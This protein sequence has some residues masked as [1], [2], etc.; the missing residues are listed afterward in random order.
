[1]KLLRPTLAALLALVAA[2]AWPQ[3]REAA[4][5]QALET[6]LAKHHVVGA[7]AAILE[8]DGTHYEIGAGFQDRETKVAADAKTIYRLGSV[9]KP[10]TAVA[11][12]QLVEAGRLSLFS[13][14]S[15]RVPEWPDKGAPISLRHLLTHTSGIRHYVAGKS[16]VFYEPFTVARSL[17]VFKDDDRLF[18]PGAKVSYSTHAFSLV[19]RLV[20]VGSKETFARY[21]AAHVSAPAGAATLRLEDRSKPDASRS[22]LYSVNSIGIATRAAREQNISWKSGGG[23][24][25]SS[26]PDLARFAMAVLKNQLTRPQTTDF[27]F[28]K[29]VVDGLDT[30]RGLGW[31]LDAQGDPAHGGAQQGCRSFLAIDRKAG[32]VVVVLTNTD[33][34]HPV[35][36]L[37][38]AVA[39]AWTSGARD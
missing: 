38:E 26:A 14:V 21:I 9:S 15:S 12:M 32:R 31:A 7:S 18:Q 8:R 13:A 16:D 17:D 34:D 28:Q 22:A 39:K 6:Y 5:R 2:A 11:A 4:V 29:Q 30:E 1:M 37:A 19:A 24:M 10:V 20:E 23:G 3:G 27:M 33:G 35:E 25:E 36:E